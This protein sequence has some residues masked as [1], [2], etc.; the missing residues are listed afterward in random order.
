MFVRFVLFAAKYPSRTLSFSKTLGLQAIF[1]G[2]NSE[3][4]PEKQIKMRQ[5]SQ[6]YRIGNLRYRHRCAEKHFSEVHHSDLVPDI[7]E[8]FIKS[9]LQQYAKMSRGISE[10]RSDC[11]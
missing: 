5:V 7:R 4:T 9:F 6:S 11:V 10:M 2:C 1:L 8:G 3:F